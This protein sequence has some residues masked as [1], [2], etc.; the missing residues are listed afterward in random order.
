MIEHN[1]GLIMDIADRIVVLDFG[2]VVA[3]GEPHE[4]MSNPKVI[5][6]YVGGGVAESE[7][8]LAAP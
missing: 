6:A 1:M 7:E 8:A 4:I 2:R 3:V 5:R